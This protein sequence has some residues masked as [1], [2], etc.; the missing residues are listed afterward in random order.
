MSGLITERELEEAEA[1]FPGIVALYRRL[2]RKPSTFLDLWRLY[3]RL[4][5]G[6]AMDGDSS[7]RMAA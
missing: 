4:T 3:L 2:K 5:E 1:V 6:E 7:A